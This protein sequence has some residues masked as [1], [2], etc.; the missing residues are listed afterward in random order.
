M[1]E[2]RITQA[3]S[4]VLARANASSKGAAITESSESGKEL[5]QAGEATKVQAIENQSKAEKADDK[6]LEGAVASANHYAQ[7]ISRDIQFSVDEEL[8]Q[9]V[10]KVLDGGSGEVI[11][12]IPEDVFLELARNLKQGGEL[13]LLD[14]LG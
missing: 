1:N 5:P 12:Q 7:S 6:K 2:V 8:K 4:Q 14:A 10:V 3:P 13:R 11:R 9:T